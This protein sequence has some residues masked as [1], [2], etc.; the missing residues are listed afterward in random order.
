M[1]LEE[2][3]EYDEGGGGGEG[4]ERG[5][6]DTAVAVL[7]TDLRGFKRAFKYQSSR[8]LDVLHLGA[9]GERALATSR[10]G[11]P[12]YYVFES[13]LPDL[14][15]NL[16]DATLRH[17]MAKNSVL[18]VDQHGRL[19]PREEMTLAHDYLRYVASF[20]FNTPYASPLLLN[21]PGTLLHLRNRCAY[22]RLLAPLFKRVDAERGS[23][24][25]L[26]DGGGGG[27]YKY[28]TAQDR[29]RENV[30]HAFVRKI[31]RVDPGRFAMIPAKTTLQSCPFAVND[32][33]TF[34]LTL[35]SHAAAAAA[36]GVGE[37]SSIIRIP[38]KTY[39]IKV[40]L[41][42]RIDRDR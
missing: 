29:T 20:M 31:A 18:F 9:A 36:A 2:E 4:D 28:M 27:K 23:C 25:F 3:D 15:L 8:P 6:P 7:E 35:H 40:I 42:D 33:I 13:L 37:R 12:R 38:S 19:F 21:S 32:C 10:N 16:A 22:A 17:P 11:E 39:L 34:R 30:T 41:V 1:E 24:A 14:G 5:E 26:R